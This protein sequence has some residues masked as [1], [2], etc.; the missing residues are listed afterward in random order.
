MVQ[1]RILCDRAPRDRECRTR[2][3][4]RCL[5]RFTGLHKIRYDGIDLPVDLLNQFPHFRDR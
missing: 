2:L 1:F 5:R 4:Q 3:F